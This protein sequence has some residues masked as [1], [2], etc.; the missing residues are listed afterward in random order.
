MQQHNEQGSGRGGKQRGY[1][2]YFRVLAGG[3]LMYLAYQLLKE[4]WMGTAET[5]LLNAVAGAAFAAAGALILRR[6]WRA[7]QYAKAHKDDPETWS[8]EDELPPAA[9]DAAETEAAETEP[10]ETTEEE[11]GGNGE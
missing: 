4:I 3:Y 1:V 11:R 10:A 5:F 9:E 8:E 6:E 7:Y 2:N